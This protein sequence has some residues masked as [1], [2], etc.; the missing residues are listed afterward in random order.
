MVTGGQLLLHPA[1]RLPQGAAAPG[2]A[3]TVCLAAAGAHRRFP[4]RPGQEF[5]PP[6]PAAGACARW[7]RKAFPPFPLALNLPSPL[8]DN[9]DIHVMSIMLSGEKWPMAADG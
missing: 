1:V 9:V 5:R 7:W 8:Y 3:A 4:A 2:V 6:R